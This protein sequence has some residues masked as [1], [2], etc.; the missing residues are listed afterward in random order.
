LDNKVNFTVVGLFV[1]ILTVAV[2]V[3]AFWLSS[4]RHD[5]VYHTYVTYVNEDVTGLSLQSPVRFNGVQVGVVEK[6]L[7][8]PNNP[9]LVKL[10]MSIEEG[11]PITTSTVVSLLPM[12]ITGVI[13]VGLKA[14][15]PHAP[16]LKVQS[17]EPYPVIP[18]QPSF[19]MQLNTVLPEIANDIKEIADSVN[20]VL[21]KENRHSINVSLTN[22]ATITKNLADNSQKMDFI[23][24]SLKKTL[25]NAA[26]ASSRFPETIKEL[27]I[28]MN[29][30]RKASVRVEL[31]TRKADTAL[32]DSHV[33]ITS[34]NEQ[35]LPSLQQVL[36]KFDATMLNMQDITEELKRN[37]SIFLRGK[38]PLPLGP[39]ESH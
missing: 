28:A 31:L 15:T 17:D 6:I 36:M 12:G 20:T 16:L 34:I 8:D 2:I 26:E 39:G 35:L 5:K 1:V 14:Q 10:V 21:S 22:I 4:K 24:D 27:N 3:I 37:P 7:L 38:E 29:A 19:L 33:M 32:G 18:F 25:Q 30:V 9:Q 11:T 13:Y 23:T